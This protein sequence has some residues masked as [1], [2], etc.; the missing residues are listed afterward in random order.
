M[1]STTETSVSICALIVSFYVLYRDHKNRQFDMLFKVMVSIRTLNRNII[2]KIAEI[3]N[4]LPQDQKGYKIQAL[5][6]TEEI[7]NEIETLAYLACRKQVNAEDVY[8][9]DG[10]FIKK[11][12]KEFNME[13][14][15][16]PYSSKLLENWADEKTKAEKRVLFCAITLF[17]SLALWMSWGLG[18]ITA[19][20]KSV[21]VVI[22]L[23]AAVL[24]SAGWLWQRRKIRWVADIHK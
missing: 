24:L 9:L 1:P 21:F 14:A 19:Q 13:Q 18:Y 2:D 6:W 20:L 5:A 8:N 17:L 7:K 10:D 23:Q 16:Y 12:V 15:E 22:I 11:T 4:A 3:E